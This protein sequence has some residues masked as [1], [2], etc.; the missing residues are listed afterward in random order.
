MEDFPLFWRDAFWEVNQW[1]GAGYFRA[2]A[3]SGESLIFQR[4][5]LAAHVPGEATFGGWFSPNDEETTVEHMSSLYESLFQAVPA[6]RWVI[7]L[8]PSYYRP[9]LF[10][11]Q[12]HALESVAERIV[13]ETNSSIQSLSDIRKIP[14][15]GFSKGNWKRNKNFLNRGGVVRLARPNEIAACYRLLAHNRHRRGVNL[16]ISES[17]FH[18][19]TTQFQAIYK[20]WLAELEEEILGAAL[21]VEIDSDNTYV[22][23]WGDSPRGREISVVASICRHLLDDA[24]DAGKRCLDLGISSEAGQLDEGLVRFKK[25]LGAADFQQFKFEV[26]TERLRYKSSSA[27]TQEGIL[28]SPIAKIARRRHVH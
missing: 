5:N 4:S 21:T 12:V 23:M 6:R 3:P 28:V 10:E 2:I 1:G 19:L 14:R 7:R 13:I 25:N 26:D 20:I 16:S 11:S 15:Y 17:Q 18:T 22:F 27:L 24:F 9:E 8:P